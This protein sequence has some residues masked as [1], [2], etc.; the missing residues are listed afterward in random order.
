[1]GTI[2][3]IYIK[4]GIV[5]AADRYWTYLNDRTR[6]ESKIHKLYIGPYLIATSGFNIRMPIVGN[7]RLFNLTF[8]L[9][10]LKHECGQD[11]YFLIDRL[12]SEKSPELE[13]IFSLSEIP[14]TLVIATPLKSFPGTLFRV[15]IDDKGKYTT[16]KA[17][18]DDGW[19][20]VGSDVKF[21]EEL[22]RE[23][24]S[25]DLTISEAEKLAFDALSVANRKDPHS[26]GYEI[27]QILENEMI[28]NPAV[29]DQYQERRKIAF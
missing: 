5:L 25:F 19:V 16:W 27:W 23:V 2:I 10:K 1:M 18:E 8:S 28:T 14:Q 29:N 17:K 12:E 26:K 7:P 20:T 24:Y 15:D 22:L 6:Y 11:K 3:G 21:I 13:K 9:E 4:K